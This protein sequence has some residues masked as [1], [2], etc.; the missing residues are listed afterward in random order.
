MSR[1]EQQAREYQEK[2]SSLSTALSLERTTHA[3]QASTLKTLRG[4]LEQKAQ[5]LGS[6]QDA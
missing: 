1:L 2:A 5:E 3:E 6:S 4:Q